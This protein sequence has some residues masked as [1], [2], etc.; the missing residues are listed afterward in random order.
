MDPGDHQWYPPACILTTRKLAKTGAVSGGHT[1]HAM[2]WILVAL[3]SALG[4]VLRYALDLL[5]RGRTGDE[6]TWGIVVANVLGSFCIGLSFA[7][8]PAG[9]ARTFVA[10]GVLGGF[11][12]F[13]TFSLHAVTYA[14][15]GRW[16]LA[17][18]YV[19]GSLV[20]ALG[21]CA[22]GLCLRRT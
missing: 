17:A 2:P 14:Q 7:L 12:T 21:G 4:G 13:S 6:A 9:A 20:G 8:L 19:A 16:G 10:T 1:L 11:T 18:A 22:L 15:Q 3:G 5:A